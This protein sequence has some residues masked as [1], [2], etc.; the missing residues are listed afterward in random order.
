M[1]EFLHRRWH[2]LRATA[3]VEVPPLRPV[4]LFEDDPLVI[5]ITRTRGRLERILF[6][7]IVPFW[8]RCVDEQEGGYRLNHDEQGVWRGSSDRHAIP[9]ARTCWFFARLA[10]ME[11]APEAALPAAWHGYRFLRDRLWDREHGGFFWTL[12]KAGLQPTDDGKRLLA[13]SFGLYAVCELGLTSGDEAVLAWSR[14]LFALIETR[15][16]D[17]SHGGYRSRA[18]R[19]WEPPSGEGWQGLDKTAGDQ[20][21]VLEAYSRFIVLSG[22][23]MVASRLVELILILTSTAVRKPYGV[24]TD[25]HRP[26]WTPWLDPADALANYGR[27]MEAVWLVLDA[28]MAAGVPKPLVV[29]WARTLADFT[30]RWGLDPRQGGVYFR[31]PLAGPAHARD[32]VWWVQAEALVG[33]LAMYRLT[34]NAAYG[35]HY[36][37]VFEWIERHHVDWQHGDWHAVVP[38]SRSLDNGKAGVW[39]SPY[40]N[41][42]AVIRC[43]ELLQPG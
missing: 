40:H 10:R 38:R 22:E 41:G 1:W 13:Q 21:H 18:T 23:Q 2:R 5:R 36:L 29:D 15:L 19:T 35:R 30:G 33:F 43:L 37:S 11:G 4:T 27:D 39:K 9:H 25:R 17:P 31:G 24:I 32:K 7:N 14:E 26:D 3:P 42:R 12:D 16:R 6:E 34:G 8:L 20:L 28:C